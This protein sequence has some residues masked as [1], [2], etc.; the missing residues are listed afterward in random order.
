MCLVVLKN[1]QRCNVNF[2]VFRP[3]VA[4]TSLFSK[5]L[6]LS[7][8]EERVRRMG[9]DGKRLR[10]REDTRERREKGEKRERKTKEGIFQQSIN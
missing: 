2:E 3:L 1:P 8:Q 6:Y 4:L 10:E 9:V 7:R 5:Y